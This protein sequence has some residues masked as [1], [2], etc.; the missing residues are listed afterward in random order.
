MAE[1]Q[2]QTIRL[3]LLKIGAL[4]R[5]TVRRCGCTWRAVARMPRCSGVSM[6]GCLGSDRWCC[7]AEREPYCRS[8]VSDARPR[9]RVPGA[10]RLPTHPERLRKGTPWEPSGVEVVRAPGGEG[11]EPSMTDDRRKHPPDDPGNLAPS[12]SVRNAGYACRWAIECTF[13][14]CKQ[15]LGVED[16]ANRLPKAVE[17][18]APMALFLFS[19][20][21]VWFHQTGHQFVRFPFRPWYPQKEE[22]S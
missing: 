20:V 16:P 11:S 2:C 15:F 7:A 9:R 22:P 21:V 12:Y 1:A 14:Y 6:R 10:V 4:V 17:R 13:E 18:T 8:I 5:V 3:K 19:M